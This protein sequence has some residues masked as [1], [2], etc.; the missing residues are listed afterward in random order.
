MR[1]KGAIYLT[2]AEKKQLMATACK[3]RME[4]CIRDSFSSKEPPPIWFQCK[5]SPF[6][7]SLPTA[8]GKKDPGRF[9][10]GNRPGFTF[11]FVILQAAPLY[12][13]FRGGVRIRDRKGLERL[14]ERGGL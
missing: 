1:M 6:F 3:V 4:M 7:P 2:A 9:P 10:Y 14:V 13:L 5:I 12:Q 8:A 11:P